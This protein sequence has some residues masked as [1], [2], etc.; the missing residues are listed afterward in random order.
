[1]SAQ[2]IDLS[3]LQRISSSNP[4]DAADVL[5]LL[6]EH[7]VRFLSLQFADI[8]GSTKGVEV[9]PRL[10]QRTIEA[11]MAFDG[12]GIEGFSRVEEP[13][14]L[15]RPDPST[16]RI[17]PWGNPEHR[18]ARIFCDVRRTGNQ[19]FEGDP[20]GALRRILAEIEAAN[21]AAKI[22]IDVEFYLFETSV[23]PWQPPAERRAAGYFDPLP[24]GREELVRRE[25]VQLLE[26]LGLEV[27]ECLS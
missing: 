19:P 27:E 20:R 3:G 11:G 12:S 1:M 22:G 25:V 5:R 6:K 16:F 7:D 24:E 4:L 21:L 2:P 14:L 18:T 9:S 13:D 10:F 23:E 15:L 8:L 17:L 26:V